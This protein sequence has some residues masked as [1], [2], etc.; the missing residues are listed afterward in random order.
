LRTP[1]AFGHC[2]KIALATVELHWCLIAMARGKSAF[3]SVRDTAPEKQVNKVLTTTG[4]TTSQRE[5]VG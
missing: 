3:K 1:A 5:I 2:I 4:S